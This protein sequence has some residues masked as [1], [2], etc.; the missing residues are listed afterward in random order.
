MVTALCGASVWGVIWYRSRA[1]TPA[2]L[3]RRMPVRDALVLY[4]DFSQL[5]RSGILPLLDGSKVG[6]E[7]EYKG[8]V[9]QTEFDYKQDLDAALVAFAPDGK[10]MLVRGRFEWKSLFAYATAQGGRCNN[11]FC[12]M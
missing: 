9:R 11:T 3:L 12:R 7:P 8:F 4:I 10:F 2:A 6:E 5:R 1:L